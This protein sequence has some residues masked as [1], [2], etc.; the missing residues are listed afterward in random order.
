MIEK[1]ANIMTATKVHQVIMKNPSK[2]SRI[3][4]TSSPNVRITG[5][6]TK[7]G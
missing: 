6:F 1:E 7:K 5:S 2:K 3:E 4:I